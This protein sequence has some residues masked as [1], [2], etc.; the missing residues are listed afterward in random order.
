MILIEIGVYI[1]IKIILLLMEDNGMKNF[2]NKKITIL[3]KTEIERIVTNVCYKKELCGEQIGK[4]KYK[5]ISIGKINQNGRSYCDNGIVPGTTYWHTH[6][7]NNPFWPSLEDIKR[8]MKYKTIEIIFSSMGIWKI[9][10]AY[11]SSVPSTL[12]KDK[13]DVYWIKFHQ[14]LENMFRGG[15]FEP[16]ELFNVIYDFK[17]E[18]KKKGY[19]LTFE[20]F[21]NFKKFKNCFKKLWK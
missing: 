18:M 6:T 14:K 1:K 20:P 17:K 2:K 13:I 19:K 16:Q 9:R 12:K 5:V 4:F 11:L 10:H 21:G 15:T 7:Y 8:C 3:T